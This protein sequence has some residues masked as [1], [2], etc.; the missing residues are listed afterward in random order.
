MAAMAS[1]AVGLTD[2]C[3][4]LHLSRSSISLLL[5]WLR[6]SS[7]NSLSCRSVSSCPN[8]MSVQLLMLRLVSCVRLETT[9]RYC[10]QRSSLVGA[11]Q[12][13]CSDESLVSCC[14]P[15]SVTGV[16]RRSR[17]VTAPRNSRQRESCRGK[18]KGEAQGQYNAMR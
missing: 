14:S 5:S 17:Y 1:M 3:G 4:T 15:S 11:R 7:R 18:K 13:F 9:H 2:G 8:E 16:P 10:D 6:S 12:S